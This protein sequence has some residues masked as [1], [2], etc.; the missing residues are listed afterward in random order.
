MLA[1]YAKGA[2]WKSTLP[3]T[4]AC[5]GEQNLPK[6]FIRCNSSTSHQSNMYQT[7]KMSQF[8]TM[9]EGGV[10]AICETGARWNQNYFCAKTLPCPASG[11]HHACS[12]MLAVDSALYPFYHSIHALQTQHQQS[13]SFGENPH[14]YLGNG[15]LQWAPNGHVGAILSKI[16][17]TVTS[18]ISKTKQACKPQSSAQRSR[19]FRIN[20]QKWSGEN[21]IDWIIIYTLLHF[22][23]TRRTYTQYPNCKAV[24]SHGL[25][26]PWQQTPFQSLFHFLERIHFLELDFYWI[27]FTFW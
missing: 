10:C 25:I 19:S 13:T 5:T 22:I 24:P 2:C 20:I 17:K 4:S 8:N 23:H 9:Q 3:C 18:T 11:F 6:I 16:F 27:C 21:I 15:H 1:L 14:M 26:L 12:V 7:C